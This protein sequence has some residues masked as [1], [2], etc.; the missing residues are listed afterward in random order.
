VSDKL[1]KQISVEREQL[2]RLLEVHAP[3]LV[4]CASSPPTPIE[5]SA[6]A[7][8]L[9][10]FYTGIENI[11][12]RIALESHSA[13][14][15]G[16]TWHRELLDLMTQPVAGRPSA[17]SP[18]LHEDLREYLQFRH[19]FRQAYSFELRWEKMRKLVLNCEPT[20]RRLEEE[21]ETFL[22]AQP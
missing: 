16:D 1:R 3:L 9:H 2:R 14:P 10:S 6:L 13:A 7:G 17:I 20:L 19:V 8:M 15:R 4:K 5:L 21:L 18:L 22:S 12:R 11:F